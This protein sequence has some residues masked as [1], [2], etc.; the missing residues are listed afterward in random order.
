MKYNLVNL[1]QSLACCCF[2][3]QCDDIPIVKWANH[4]PVSEICDRLIAWLLFWWKN[5]NPVLVSHRCTLITGKGCTVYCTYA[6][7]L[8]LIKLRMMMLNQP[9]DTVWFLC[10]SQNFN[11]GNSFIP[12]F[13]NIFVHNNRHPPKH[14]ITFLCIFCTYLS[15]SDLISHPILEW[16]LQKVCF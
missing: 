16:R 8:F 5:M 2:L 9:S 4:W 3:W 14:Y 10:G 12:N 1:L 6:M 15:L 7:S 11:D 13:F